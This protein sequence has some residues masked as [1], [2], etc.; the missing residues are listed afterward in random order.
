MTSMSP[1]ERALLQEFLQRLIQ[2][3]G[4]EK[5]PRADALI[6]Q[7]VSQQ[8]DAAYL[9][10]QRALLLEQ[11][12]DAAKAEIAQ[13]NHQ[14]RG[15]SERGFL[16][17]T[18]RWGR[19]EQPAQPAA[20]SVSGRPISAEPAGTLPAPAAP[21]ARS[22]FGGFLGQAAATAA[23]VAGG[24]FLFQGLESLLGRHDGLGSHEQNEHLQGDVTQ[25]QIDARPFDA[26]PQDITSDIDWDDF[27]G[28]DDAS[29]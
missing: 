16:S 20:P 28:P 14:L 25:E 15:G 22:P 3:R 18:D 19:R 26:N 24:A 7:A 2:I 9:L 17:G 12:L 8:P 4:I 5:D 29:V 23:G 1:Q 10:V 13:L 21:P 27:D 6:A 11:A